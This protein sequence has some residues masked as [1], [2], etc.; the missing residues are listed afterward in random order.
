MRSVCESVVLSRLQDPAN[1]IEWRVCKGRRSA[2]KDGCGDSS[3]VCLMT[4]APGGRAFESQWK[5]DTM[6]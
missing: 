1:E 3:S 4:S 2:V 5:R 6:G